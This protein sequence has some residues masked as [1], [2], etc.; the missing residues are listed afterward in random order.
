MPTHFKLWA[1]TKKIVVLQEVLIWLHNFQSQRIVQ[2]AKKEQ[3]KQFCT[4]RVFLT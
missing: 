1:E 2:E 3:Q 4:V